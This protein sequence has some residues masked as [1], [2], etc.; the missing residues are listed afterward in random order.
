MI[1]RYRCNYNGQRME[2]EVEFDKSG[3]GTLVR[4]DNDYIRDAL[5]EALRTPLQYET[6]EF[7]D[8]ALAS[9]PIYAKPG[10]PEHARGM[11]NPFILV[12]KGIQVAAI[13]GEL[14]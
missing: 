8:G 5:E 2:A 14:L 4:A 12:R 10:T 1:I 3:K 13:E 9:V 6:G 7:R 11:I